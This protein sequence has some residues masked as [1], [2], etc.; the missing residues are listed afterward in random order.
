VPSVAGE[1]E[2]T[3]TAVLKNAGLGWSIMTT[4]ECLKVP[5]NYVVSQDPVGGSTALPGSVVTLIV[6]AAPTTT[7]TTAPTTTTTTTT[8]LQV[9]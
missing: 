3:A 9:P 2:K 8:Q 4:T 1:H 5:I 6:C 7:T